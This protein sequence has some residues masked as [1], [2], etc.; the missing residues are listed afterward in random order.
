MLDRVAVEDP[1]DV[2]EPRPRGPE[3]VRVVVVGT[4]RLYREGLALSL[5]DRGGFE[6][7][8]SVSE[9]ELAIAAVQEH[10]PDIVL[11]D[12]SLPGA[13]SLVREV[14]ATESGT[15]VVAFAVSETAD[16]VLA[17]AEAG[18]AGYVP[19][20]GSVDDL[21]Y[22]LRRAVRGEIRVPPRIAGAIFQR[23]AALSAPTAQTE[24]VYQLTPRELEILDLIAEG[25]ANKQ[26]ARRLSIRV[27]TVKNNVHHIHE[28]LGV[29]TRGAAAARLHDFRRAGYG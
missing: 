17:C 19:A 24:S 10:R 7:L 23:L 15:R 26:I 8:T 29:T 14:R 4:V 12:I 20:D 3:V 27:A 13:H 6:V 11:M 22:T 16:A 5:A 25:L 9:P 21:T 1:T 28:Q 2:P 18:I